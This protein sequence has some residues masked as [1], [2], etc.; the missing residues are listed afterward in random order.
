MKTTSRLICGLV[1]ILALMLVAAIWWQKRS[2]P[3]KPIPSSSSDGRVVTAES[4]TPIKAPPSGRRS[5][6]LLEPRDLVG[7]PAPKAVAWLTAKLDSGEDA[8]TGEG[9]VPG[10]DGYLRQAPTLRVQ[11][12][13]E[14]GQR[15][16]VAA[17]AE[18][19]KILTA[20]T[21]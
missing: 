9:F 20:P 17:A 6:A 11:W 12:L 2:H 7:L 15:D 5:A 4:G 3:V 1:L 8:L 14:L 16:P 21:T 18:A 10:P 13:G 19:E